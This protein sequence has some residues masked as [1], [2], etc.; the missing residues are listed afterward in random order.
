MTKTFA[1]ARGDLTEIK[2][3]SACLCS[4]DSILAKAKT[5]YK[6]LKNEN[7]VHDHL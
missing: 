1:R 7:G 3:T 2:R 5:W 6:N 4:V